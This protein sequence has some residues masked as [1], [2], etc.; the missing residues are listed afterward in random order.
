VNAPKFVRTLSKDELRDL[1]RTISKGRDARVVRRAQIIRLS[2]RGET[3]PQIAELMG[4]SIPTIHRVIDAFN[5]EGIASLADKPRP[6][7]PAKATDEY[8]RLLKEAVMTSPREMGYPFSS[9][10]TS[11]LR[12]H[13][14]RKC[15]IILHPDYLARLMAKHG[16]VYRRPRHIM[17]HLQDPKDY[18]EKKEL[19]E[20]LKKTPLRDG[21]TST[22]CSS[23]NVK[24]TSIRH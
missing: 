19:I 7:R 24:F 1:S 6:G 14:A 8:V 4:F 22:C 16:I 15:G 17:G 20:F 12:E 11:R 9:W 5:A 18:N 21:K 13:L 10:T 2:A 3:S 23:T